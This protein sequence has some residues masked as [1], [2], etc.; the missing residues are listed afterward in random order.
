MILLEPH[1]EHKK[2]I[3]QPQ[4]PGLWAMSWHSWT[5]CVSKT[6]TRK[7]CFRTA[8]LVARWF[9]TRA[10]GI[11]S[12]A[13]PPGFAIYRR[14]ASAKPFCVKKILNLCR[15]ELTVFVS[16]AIF[17]DKLTYH[18]F[19]IA[20][21]HLTFACLVDFAKYQREDVSLRTNSYANGNHSHKNKLRAPVGSL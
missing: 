3:Q 9:I 14:E 1:N 21:P 19:D 17:P 11:P 2:I 10:R 5:F 13:K 20:S 18:F 16:V 7:R 6:P 4:Q 15:S 12:H 8:Q